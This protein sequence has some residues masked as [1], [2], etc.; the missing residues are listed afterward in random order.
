MSSSS[1]RPRSRSNS[2]VREKSDN[3]SS[4]SLPLPSA[5]SDDSYKSLCASK[6]Y[7]E[8]FYLSPRERS[9][10]KFSEIPTIKE[11]KLIHRFLL[12]IYLRRA[13]NSN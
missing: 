3:I 12:T 8:K 5:I 9:P 11:E 4:P 1:S 6:V 2:R 13:F 7:V 10:L